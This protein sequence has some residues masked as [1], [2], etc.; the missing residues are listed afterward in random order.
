M[1]RNKECYCGS[2]KKFKKCHG[3]IF[4]KVALFARRGAEVPEFEML[5]LPP[6]IEGIKKAAKINIHLLDEV[7]KLIKPGV[8]TATLDK[9]IHDTTYAMGGVPAT[10]GYDGYPNSSCISLN[11]IV[12]HG[13]PDEETILEE[14][15]I[16]NIDCTTIFDGFYADASRMYTVG[17]IS[18]ERQKL[19]DVAKE[20]LNRGVAAVKPWGFTGDIGHAVQTYVESLGYSVVTE[21]GGHGIG[22]EFHEEP[23]IA[24]VGTPGDGMLMVPGMVFTIEPMI[25]AGVPDLFVDEDDNWTAFT[26][27]GKDSAQW[28]H[29][30]LVTETGCEVLVY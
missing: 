24:H 14:G 19:V 20:A 12:C 18:D 29:T 10:L 9:F 5:K 6:H 13:I 22:I 30:V 21:F 25:N 28:E 8:S 16:L 15:D 4:D 27:D 11:E 26:A 2:G 17:N 23:F 1:D 3:P 7:A